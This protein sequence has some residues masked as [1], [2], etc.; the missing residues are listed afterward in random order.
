ME[1]SLSPLVRSAMASVVVLVALQVAL[2]ATRD[3][4]FLS[5]FP[6]SALPAMIAAGAVASIVVAIVA[7]RALTAMGPRRFVPRA[8]VAG[9]LVM[10]AAWALALVA[11]G[12]GA[13]S[14]LLYTSDAADEL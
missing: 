3:T 10:L 6:V 13:T 1:S 11:P 12:P 5:H 9:A 14:C 7:T 2:R 4:L 8:F